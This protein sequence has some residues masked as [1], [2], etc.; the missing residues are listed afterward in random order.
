[1]RPRAGRLGLLDGPAASRVSILA[2][3]DI[4]TIVEAATNASPVALIVDSVQTATSDELDGPAGSVGQAAGLRPVQ[5]MSVREK[6]RGSRS[7]WPGTSRRTARSPG[8]RPSNTSSMPYVEPRGRAVAALRLL[9]ASKNRFGFDRGDRGL[10]DGRGA[11]C[12]EVADP[13]RAV[14]RRP[15][16]PPRPPGSVVAPT[17][18]GSRPL[19][20]EVQ[21]LVSPAT[22][23]TPV[24]RASGLDQNRLTLL[25]AV[26]GR[27]AG[28]ALVS[29]DVYATQL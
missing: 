26:L 29:H 5:L 25:T 24:R 13:A 11:A 10:R 9:R 6:G 8:R 3:H 14:P 17:M 2:E 16:P 4:A 27:R 23:G 28:I 19:L 12:L 7:S 21:A 15:V 18:E 22:Y 1:M 20:V